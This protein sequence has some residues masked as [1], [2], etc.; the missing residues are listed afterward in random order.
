VEWHFKQGLAP[1]D[2]SFLNK[3]GLPLDEE[4]PIIPGLY[5]DLPCFSRFPHMIFFSGAPNLLLDYIHLFPMASV[6]HALP[7]KAVVP[8]FT[9]YPILFS[10]T[11]LF[12]FSFDSPRGNRSPHC[13]LFLKGG[14]TCFHLFPGHLF[15]S[16][17]HFLEVLW[18][19]Y[20][21]GGCPYAAYWIKRTAWLNTEWN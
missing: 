4:E 5:G 6:L 3:A 21:F 8:T 16:T 20:S 19:Q 15:S 12:V 18:L 13:R 11:K 2:P 17:G 14:L 9:E 1:G 10:T 7:W